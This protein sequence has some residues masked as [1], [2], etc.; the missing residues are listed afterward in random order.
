L[1]IF[2]KA[3]RPNAGHVLLILEVPRPHSITHHSR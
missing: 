2:P 3:L 1:L